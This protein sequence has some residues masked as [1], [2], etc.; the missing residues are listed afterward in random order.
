MSQKI[1]TIAKISMRPSRAIEPEANR[2]TRLQKELE[3][4]SLF[5]KQ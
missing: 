2:E 1:R 4:V 3:Q 5:S